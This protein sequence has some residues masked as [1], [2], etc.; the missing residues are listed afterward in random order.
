[1]TPPAPSPCLRCGA[2]CATFRVS[3]YWGEAVTLGLEADAVEKV[4]PHLICMAGTNS[5]ASRCH[6]LHGTVG[7]AVECGLYA[8]RPSPCRELQPGEDKCNR[9]RARHG[10]APIALPGAAPGA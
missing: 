6:A 2:C 1:M 5:G 4:T 10:L 8:K 7:Q 3:F 9:A